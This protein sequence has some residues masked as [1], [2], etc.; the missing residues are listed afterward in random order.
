MR[1]KTNK[2]ETITM[3]KGL[4]FYEKIINCAPSQKGRL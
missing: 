1:F 2:K 4:I 3:F